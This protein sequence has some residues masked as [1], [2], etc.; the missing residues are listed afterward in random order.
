METIKRKLSPDEEKRFVGNGC[1]KPVRQ[2]ML[3]G[4][5][6]KANPCLL[7]LYG[8]QEPEYIVNHSRYSWNIDGYVLQQTVDYTHYAVFHG[9]NGHL[10]S[11]PSVNYIKDS[12]DSY[13]LCT[14]KGYRTSVVE[15]EWNNQERNYITKRKVNEKY[16][17]KEFYPVEGHIC[18]DYY[19]SHSYQDYVA[20]LKENH[21][22]FQDCEVLENP[23]DLF[24][25]A[26]N[27]IYDQTVIDMFSKSRVYGR[28]KALKQFM[29]SN[30]SVEEY[31]TLLKIA[32][33]ELACGIFQELTIAKNPILLKQAKEIYKSKDLWGESA[34][35][36]G[37]KR[38]LKLYIDVFDEK[39]MQKQ[40]DAVYRSLPEMDFHVTQLDGEPITEEE[41]KKRFDTE[42]LS[43]AY[44]RMYEISGWYFGNRKLYDKNTYTD[45]KYFKKMAFK[46]TIQTAKAYDM[47]D[48]IGKIA[49]CL[50]TPR[51]TYFLKSTGQGRTYDYFVRYLRRTIDT[52]QKTD[53]TKFIAAAKELLS[54]YTNDDGMQGFNFDY[55]YQYNYFFNRYFAAK[56]K[57][58]IQP[59]EDVWDR[60]LDDVVEIAK[61]AKSIP[62]SKFCDIVIRKAY[63]NHKFDNYSLKD[64]IALTQIPYQKTAELFEKL[65]LPKLEA[66]QEFDGELMLSLMDTVLVNLQRAAEDYF[67][68]TDGKFSPENTA[69]MFRLNSF[70]KWLMIIKKNV[71]DFTPK[72]Y[73]VFLKNFLM[74]NEYFINSKKELS[75]NVKTFL[76][77]SVAV[78]NQA[79]KEEK[80]DIVQYLVSTLY[81]KQELIDFMTEM[82]EGI[83]FQMPYDELKEI[84][85]HVTFKNNMLQERTRNTV[86]L[87]R[88]IKEDRVC[89]DT[90]LLSILD[91]GSAQQVKVLTEVAEQLKTQFSNAALLLLFESNVYALN[92]TAKTVFESMEPNQREKLHMA[93]IDSPL[94]K[95]HQYALEKLDTWYGNKIPKTFLYR[96]LEHPS[97]AVKTFL[98]EKMEKAFSNLKEVQP[99]LYLYYVKTLLYLPNKVSK[100]KDEVYD[101]IPV[102]LSYCPEKRKEIED[103]LLDI[104]STHVKLNSEKALVTFAKIQRGVCNL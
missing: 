38:F 86:A 91:T 3:W 48:A 85:Q 43:Y 89:K 7:I 20:Y 103:I 96:M 51:T 95:V 21:I 81:Q 42:E 22:V 16:K 9:M 35:H 99:D 24:G 52:Y 14:R 46:H 58:G 100:S 80:Q 79:T 6:Q 8:E 25:F 12:K 92:Q 61:N 49:Y 1:Q 23:S 68:R 98:S 18:F 83:L 53:E 78:L 69:Q 45:G 32:S 4:K 101:T 40:K 15:W 13:A 44:F 2:I 36:T 19:E 60:H 37:L 10:P 88:A 29:E 104:G 47:A 63:Q 75:D 59:Q 11:I 27:S 28:Q 70:E 71:H 31:E 57:E 64:L 93:L 77:N 102:F 5:D 50:D 97:I 26:E 73:I 56:I 82:V 90:V 66:L 54:S 39:L 87:L 55:Y 34:Y 41:L 30:P 72:E 76:K 65:V 67:V 84:L 62:T 33:I 94:E 17:I 74:Q